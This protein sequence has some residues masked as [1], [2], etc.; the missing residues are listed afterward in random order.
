MSSVAEVPAECGI[1]IRVSQL[2]LIIP[3]PWVRVPPAPQT[4]YSL[5]Q[6][7]SWLNDSMLIGLHSGLQ[8]SIRRAGVCDAGAVP[9]TPTEVSRWQRMG[10]RCGPDA[11]DD[12]P[13]GSGSRRGVPVTERGPLR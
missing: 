6:S 12:R 11:R 7:L 1:R 4:P 2:D 10:C 13:S 8:T 9:D 3:G 5:G